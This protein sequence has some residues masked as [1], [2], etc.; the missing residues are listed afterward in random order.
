MFD[1]SPAFQRRV[2][3]QLMKRYFV[4][5][6]VGATLVAVG[7]FAVQHRH[8]A[9]THPVIAPEQ[10]LV[11][12]REQLDAAMAK[13]ANDTTALPEVRA[14]ALAAEAKVDALFALDA[15]LGSKETQVYIQQESEH[16]TRVSGAVLNPHP[17]PRLTSPELAA[18]QEQMGGIINGLMPEQQAD[19]LATQRKVEALT[20][21]DAFLGTSEEPI[22]FRQE[23]DRQ[24]RVLD[25]MRANVR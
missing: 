15:R 14:D 5:M 7:S 21:L 12:I 9:S 18:L 16:W 19:A 20:A 17:K 24:Q 10:R 23:I 2:K 11:Q 3:W 13:T 8:S 25:V 1:N 6:L 4:G 22:F